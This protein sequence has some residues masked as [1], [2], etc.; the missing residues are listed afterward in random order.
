LAFRQLIEK[1]E[2]AQAQAAERIQLERR[3]NELL[4][5]KCEL[6]Q[7]QDELTQLHTQRTDLLSKLRRL[8]DERFAIRE[9][10]G[11][12]VNARLSPAIRV[13]V[14][15]LADPACYRR[16]LEEWLCVDV[17]EVHG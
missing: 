6:R 11:Q 4:A 8:Q 13:S 3:R 14:A 16:S 5:K 1:H 15:Q 9:S 10:V 2:H 17:G 12:R 7:L